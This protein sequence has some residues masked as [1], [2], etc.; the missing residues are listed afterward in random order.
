MLVRTTAPFDLVTLSGGHFFLSAHQEKVAEVITDGLAPFLA[1]RR[2]A[3]SDG[4]G[5]ASAQD[6]HAETTHKVAL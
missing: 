1:H 5:V 4:S 3:P 6:N 2:G